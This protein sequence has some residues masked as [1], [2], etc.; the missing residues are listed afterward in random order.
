[1]GEHSTGI[2]MTAA[3]LKAKTHWY[4]ITLN[5]M[6]FHDTMASGILMRWHQK[7]GQLSRTMNQ[8][9]FDCIHI[10]V[11]LKLSISSVSKSTC[12]SNKLLTIAVQ[13]V[14]PHSSWVISQ[15][16]NTIEICHI[17]WEF[18]T[19]EKLWYRS[20]PRILHRLQ[21]HCCF[22]NNVLKLC[23]H[24]QKHLRGKW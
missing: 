18:A 4:H 7:Q 3:A 15:Q 16:I 1:M 6:N 5:Q 20:M 11:I 24:Q 9:Q 10:C 19:P 23:L 17:S 21:C 22:Y 12:Q 8:S 14:W 13:S 2:C